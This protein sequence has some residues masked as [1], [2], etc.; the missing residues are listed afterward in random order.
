MKKAAIII[1]LPLLLLA[2]YLISSFTIYQRLVNEGSILADNQCLKVNPLIIG[3]KNSYIKSIQALENNDFEGYEGE[4]VAY[5]EY[6]KMYVS[7]QAKW[8]EEQKKYMDRW[9]FKYFIPE[10]MKN[11]AMTQYAAREADKKS[12]EY[13][14]DS[15]E[16]YQLNESLAQDLS[17]KAMQQIK[18]RN[19]AEKKY[20]D[21]WDNPGKLDWRTRFIRAPESKCPDENFD[22][23][24]VDDFL[25]PQPSHD[26][27]DAPLS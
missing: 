19:D 26:N 8:L 9:E 11:A 24:D 27:P 13:L 20:D 12:T 18:I 21:L 17:N 1:T 7:E 10:Y 25:N 23:P 16:V 3:R 15:F 22:I 2:V 6:S 4:T 14:I 5:F